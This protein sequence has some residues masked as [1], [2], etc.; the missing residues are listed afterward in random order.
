[1]LERKEGWRKEGNRLS[2]KKEKKLR[3]VEERRSKRH[4]KD[5][6]LLVAVEGSTYSPSHTGEQGDIPAEKHTGTHTMQGPHAYPQTFIPSPGTLILH[7]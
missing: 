3:E 1:L 4:K 6:K 5:K 7:T 2:W